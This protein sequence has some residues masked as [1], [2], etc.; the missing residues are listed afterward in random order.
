MKHLTYML[1]L[2]VSWDALSQTPEERAQLHQN[3]HDMRILME[4]SSAD[5][6]ARARAAVIG[7]YTG[8]AAADPA[9]ASTEVMSIS[10]MRQEMNQSF[11]RIE[12]MFPCLG[13]N[14]DVED[15]QAILICGDNQGYAGNDNFEYEDN[16]TFDLR[17]DNSVNI[18]LPPSPL[19]KE[20]EKEQEQ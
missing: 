5:A 15:G 1:L 12:N 13:A 3:V 16:D 10:Q 20:T 17:Q 11:E 19:E 6:D 18:N 9:V 4:Q 7:L 8:G 14:I 2:I